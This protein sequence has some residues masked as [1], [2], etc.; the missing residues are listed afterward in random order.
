MIVCLH[1]K[2]SATSVRVQLERRSSTQMRIVCATIFEAG[3]EQQA[4]AP[5]EPESLGT[6]LETSVFRVWKDTIA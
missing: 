4:N 2:S 5:Q 3:S 1:P 6:V